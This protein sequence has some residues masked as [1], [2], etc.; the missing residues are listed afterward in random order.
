[1]VAKGHRVF[2]AID[3]IPPKTPRS[4]FRVLK[5]QNRIFQS[6]EKPETRDLPPRDPL[7]WKSPQPMPGASLS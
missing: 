6:K 1:M 2:T 7:K 3:L 5:P 4:T